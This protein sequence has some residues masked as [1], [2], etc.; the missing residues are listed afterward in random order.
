MDAA[1]ERRRYASHRRDTGYVGENR[2]L[3]ARARWG[4]GMIHS[5]SARRADGP[6]HSV[7][8][9]GRRPPQKRP[10]GSGDLPKPVHFVSAALPSGDHGDSSNNPASPWDPAPPRDTSPPAPGSLASNTVVAKMMKRMNYKEGTG[11]GRRGQGIVA[12]VEVLPRPK[13]AGLGTAEGR[14][15]AGDLDPLPPSAENWPKWDE[16]GGSSKKRTKRDPVVF[17]DA[18]TFSRRMEE[19]AAAEAVARV[20][21]ALARPPRWSSGGGAQG[22][23][24]TAAAMVISKAMERVR[25]EIVSGALTAGALAREFTALKE[26]FPREYAVFR[27]ADAAR[28]IAA[29]LLHRTVF[30]QWDPLEDPSRGLEAVAWLRAAL[31]DDGSDT[32][33]RRRTLRWSTTS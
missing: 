20:Q 27:L 9:Y 3:D 11:L 28:A 24:E 8:E 32:R 15:T 17:E 5:L 16:A 21:K 22:K 18:K 26:R 25:E 7:A 6:V 13:N 12:P 23:E 14:F 4:T 29:M 19:S 10:R 1:G 33:T 30:Q 31:L 2:R